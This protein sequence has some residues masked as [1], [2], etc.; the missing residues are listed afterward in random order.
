MSGC[1]DGINAHR[2]RLLPGRFFDFAPYFFYGMAKIAEGSDDDEIEFV[3]QPFFG[4]AIGDADKNH[5]ILFQGKNT[6]SAKPGAELRF[7]NGNLDFSKRGVPELC[8]VGGFHRGCFLRLCS[9]AQR[10][11]RSRF[12]CGYAVDMWRKVVFRIVCI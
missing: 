4:E 9:I 7:G 11:E 8:R 12:S 1:G 10:A 3:L 6:R 5:A 2:A